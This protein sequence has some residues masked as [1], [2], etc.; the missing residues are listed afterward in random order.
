MKSWYTSKVFWGMVAL[1]VLMTLQIVQEWYARGDFSIPGIIGLAIA[2]IVAVIRI[3]FT[4]Q[5]IDTPKARA[6]ADEAVIVAESG[7][8]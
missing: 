6:K 7:R 3:W 4:D 2:I 5:A 1:F 8:E